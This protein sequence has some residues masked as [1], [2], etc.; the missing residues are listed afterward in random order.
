MSDALTTESKMRA[1]DLRSDTVTRPSEGMLDA[2]MSADVDDDVFESDP[3]V[4]RLQEMAASFFGK[5]AALFCPSGT[6]T[7]QIAIQL[8]HIN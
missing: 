7:N 2:M 1:I 3:S 8:Q 6:M 4:N 5:E